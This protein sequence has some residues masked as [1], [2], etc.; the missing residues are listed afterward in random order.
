MDQEGVNTTIPPF[1]PMRFMSYIKDQDVVP[2]MY[3]P[4]GS[5]H[6]VDLSN[7]KSIMKLPN[8]SHPL[9][10]EWIEELKSAYN[11]WYI[12]PEYGEFNLERLE[13]ETKVYDTTNQAPPEYF[14]TQKKTLD[15]MI[16]GKEELKSFALPENA[17]WLK[18]VRKW[19]PNYNP[20]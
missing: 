3:H 13:A 9:V 14:E 12:H 2:I 11:G 1:H 15:E 19:F 18:E 4:G 5:Y 7:F 6:I 10:K 20:N 17:L 8:I 16:K